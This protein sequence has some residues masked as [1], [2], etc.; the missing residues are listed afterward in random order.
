[1]TEYTDNHRMFQLERKKHKE[2]LKM[3]N[4]AFTIML[5]IAG[6]MIESSNGYLYIPSCKICSI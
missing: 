1:M 6:F 4:I 5:L 2:E 3:K